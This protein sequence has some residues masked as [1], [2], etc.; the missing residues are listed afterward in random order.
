[1]R[2]VGAWAGG[3]G[4]GRGAFDEFDEDARFRIHEQFANAGVHDTSAPVRIRGY[5]GGLSL[6][7]GVGYADG[8]IAAVAFDEYDEASRFQVHTRAETEERTQVVLTGV[9]TSAAPRPDEDCA[10]CLASLL[11]RCVATPCVHCFH[12]A[13]LETHVRTS[14]RSG[15]PRCPTCRTSLVGPEATRA[16][17]TQSQVAIG[18]AAQ[19]PAPQAAPQPPPET[20]PPQPPPPQRPPQPPP[21]AGPHEP[22]E[23]RDNPSEPRAPVDPAAPPPGAPPATSTRARARRTTACIMI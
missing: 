12:L 6:P 14:A 8:Q 20:H 22:S 9:L 1:M 2:S 4:G 13:C 11:D 18:P 21:A 10:I 17:D 16:H 3:A 5:A 19:A 15:P 7:G 23:D